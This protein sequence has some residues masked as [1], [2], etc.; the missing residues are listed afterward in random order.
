MWHKI[1]E[2]ATTY[3]NRFLTF[4]T[5]LIYWNLFWKLPNNI[6]T[7]VSSLFPLLSKAN[8]MLSSQSVKNFGDYGRTRIEYEAPN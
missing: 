1:A 4:T 3:N 8:E 5:R 2:Y 7:I 6:I